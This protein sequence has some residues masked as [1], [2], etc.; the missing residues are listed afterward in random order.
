MNEEELKQHAIQFLKHY[1]SDSLSFEELE[2]W[3]ID[4]LEYWKELMRPEKQP[5]Y[6]RNRPN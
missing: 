6:G 3:Y 4:F 2:E 5:T 1:T